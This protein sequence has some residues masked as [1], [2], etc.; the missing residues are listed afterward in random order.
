MFMKKEDDLEIWKVVILASGRG[1][2]C[3]PLTDKTPKPMLKVRRKS[4]LQWTLESVSK[5]P[6]V[7]EIIITVDWLKE[8]IIKK[9]GNSFRGI[10]IKYIEIPHIPKEKIKTPYH[11]HVEYI[12]SELNATTKVSGAD[13]YLRF[14]GDVLFDEN[15]V[16][17]IANKVR[18][19]SSGFWGMTFSFYSNFTRNAL[20]QVMKRNKFTMLR[21]YGKYFALPFL[22]KTGLDFKKSKYDFY[23]EL[24]SITLS[25]E[26]VSE[27]EKLLECHKTELKAQKAFVSKKDYS[28]LLA[29][30]EQLVLKQHIDTLEQLQI[31][32]R[33]FKR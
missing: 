29:I 11:N 8:Q 27:M 18:K 13:Y 23:N 7:D 22:K 19:G 17:L 14:N 25:H 26:S 16:K 2:R 30:G 24:L 21:M 10:P 4:L 15:A 3:A 12:E 9:F 1:K 31:L 32:N 20:L 33:W 5:I 6:E 28:D